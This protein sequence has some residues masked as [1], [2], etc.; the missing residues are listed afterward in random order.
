MIVCKQCFNFDEP[1]EEAMFNYW[2]WFDATEDFDDPH[3]RFCDICGREFDE[4]ELVVVTE[5]Q[6]IDTQIIKLGGEV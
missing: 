5:N 4:G 1:W 6:K 2:D 3:G